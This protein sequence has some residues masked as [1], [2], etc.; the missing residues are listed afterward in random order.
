MAKASFY[1]SRFLFEDKCFFWEK[2]QICQLFCTLGERLSHIGCKR[3]GSFVEFAMYV[4]RKNFL[5]EKFPGKEAAFNFYFDFRQNVSILSAVFFG[6]AFH[7][8]LVSFL[9]KCWSHKLVEK[10]RGYDFSPI[11]SWRISHFR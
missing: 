9:E 4:T 1:Q 5:G 8:I 7:K 11:L 2:L 6:L 3:S 10:Q